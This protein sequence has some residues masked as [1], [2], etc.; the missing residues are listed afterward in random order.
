MNAETNATESLATESLATATQMK[1]LGEALDAV[2]AGSGPSYLCRQIVHSDLA[3]GNIRG[4]ALFVLD[5]KSHLKPVASYG[6]VTETNSDL[7]A[8]DD[9]P[10]A[11]AIR[12]KT[13]VS[14]ST[15][16][17]DQEL[18]VH[19]IPLAANGVPSGLA[20]LFIDQPGYRL[21]WPLE[22]AQIVSKLGAFYLHSLD[23]GPNAVGKALETE[24]IDDPTKRQLKILNHIDHGLINGEIAQ[25]LMLS[26][27]TIRQETVR[28]YK[29]LGVGNRQEA[30]KKAKALGFL[31]RRS[32]SSNPA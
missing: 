9:S 30:V 15:R 31:S 18:S 27:S 4:C 17:K 20:A 1:A 2:L 32:V 28:I 14:G 16:I 22:L 8:W 3:G 29:S 26:E 24:D 25:E 7:S 19:A 10:L 5:N 13:I 21:E 12:S 11:E 23:S 6:Q